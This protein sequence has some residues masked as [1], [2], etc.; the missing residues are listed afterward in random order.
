MQ[1]G[2]V[3]TMLLRSVYW[4]RMMRVFVIPSIV[5]RKIVVA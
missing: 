2:C 3:W 5:C 4:T 1:A